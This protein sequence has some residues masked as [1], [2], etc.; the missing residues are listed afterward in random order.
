ML[1][2]LPAAEAK[3]AARPPVGGEAARGDAAAPKEPYPTGGLLQ[4]APAPATAADAWPWR[5]GLAATLSAL[6][7]RGRVA[8]ADP[9]GSQ[10][11]LLVA[12][13]TEEESSCTLASGV[14]QPLDTASKTLVSA[15]G[16]GRDR[17]KGNGSCRGTVQQQASA[18]K[19]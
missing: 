14:A 2:L 15:S 6:L 8:S 10:G 16:P 9:A 19:G 11:L 12:G 13:V 5:V 18:T 3:R 17:V 7:S 4:A 1:L